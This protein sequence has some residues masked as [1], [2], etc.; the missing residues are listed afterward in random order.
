MARYALTLA[1]HTVSGT[2][3]WATLLV[4]VLGSIIIGIIAVKLPLTAVT[5]RALLVTGILGG[6]TTM[7]SFS[8]EV[9][10]LAERG[11][12]GMAGIYAVLTFVLC[13]TGCSVGLFL[14]HYP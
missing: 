2:W 13:L 8:L 11:H 9:M 10:T 5:T 7:S 3:P 12:V 6:F 1:L 4:N 14:S